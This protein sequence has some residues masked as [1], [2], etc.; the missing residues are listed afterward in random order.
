MWAKCFAVAP[1]GINAFT[2][3]SRQEPPFQCGHN[4][5]A[6]RATLLERDYNVLYSGPC[7]LRPLLQPEKY[8]LKWKVVLKLRD[9][10]IENIRMVS[11][12][13]SWS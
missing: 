9:I 4:F 7:I 5:L 10:Y 11:L 3:S 6:N 1:T 13:D 12:H 2:S 8:S